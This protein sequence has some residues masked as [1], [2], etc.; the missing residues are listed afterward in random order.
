MDVLLYI[1]ISIVL[2]FCLVGIAM[3]NDINDDE[4]EEEDD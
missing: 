3:N 1:A 2:Q 4:V